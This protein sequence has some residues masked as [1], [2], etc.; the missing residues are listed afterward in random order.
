MLGGASASAP[1][2]QQEPVTPAA[3]SF[4]DSKYR[5]TFQ[6]PAGW[7]FAQKDGEL[8]TFHLDARSAGRN[9]QLRAVANL[10]F[11]PYPRATFSGALFYFSVQP[12]ASAAECAT[13]ASGN[14]APKVTQ[15]HGASFTQG[16]DEHGTIC[17]DARDEVYT[18]RRAGACYRFDLAMNSFCGGEVSGAKDMTQGEMD[19]I[20]KRMES[21][22][23]TV[24]IEAK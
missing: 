10:A 19:N 11:N 23:N 5:V 20:R 15:V 21:I 17:I 14:A 24:V 4:H 22:L 7:N 18:T 16:H 13:E 3:R 1:G 2:Q 6:I 8:S 12:H 9:A